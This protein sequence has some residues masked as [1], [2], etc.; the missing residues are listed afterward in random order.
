MK[1]TACFVLATLFATLGT[2][3]AQD[4]PIGIWFS[5]NQ[6]AI[7][8]V[9][10]MGFTWIQAYGGYDRNY[11]NNQILQNNRGLNVAAILERNIHNPSFAQRMF[12]EAERSD[13][14]NGTRNY[15]TAHPTGGSDPFNPDVWRASVADHAAGYMVR[16]PDPA[17]QYFYQCVNWVATANISIDPTGNPTDQVVR[18]EILDAD[19]NLIADRI[20]TEGEFGGS[21]AFREFE[22]AYTLPFTPTPRAYQYPVSASQQEPELLLQQQ[23]HSVDVR[24]WWYDQVNTYLDYVVLEDSVMHPNYSGAYQLFRGARDTAITNNASSLFLSK[25]TD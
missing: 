10:A 14:E 17:N 22:L 23:D 19:S 2:A 15:F 1:R 21:A 25:K 18:L 7:D 4:F 5:G 8:S 24:V 6:N 12:Y 13:S 3:H 16:S 20:I 9:D 11:L